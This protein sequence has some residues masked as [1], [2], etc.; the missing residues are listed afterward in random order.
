MVPADRVHEARLQLAG[1]GLPKG[2][3]TG[4]ELLDKEQGLGVSQ[5]MENAQYQRALEG[6]L[7]RTIGSIS[8]VQTARVHLAVPKQS[9]FVRERDKNFLR[10]GDAQCDERPATRC[11]TGGG[12]RAF[13]RVE[14]AE[15]RPTASRWWINRASC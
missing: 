7:A 5:F 9:S 12:D 10:L 4:F 14:R 13:G 2:S 6:E 8:G 11:R 1:S 15:S 3:A